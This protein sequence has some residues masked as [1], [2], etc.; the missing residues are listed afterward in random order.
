MWVQN[1][2]LSAINKTH[3]KCG[4]FCLWRK[5]W[6]VELDHQSRWLC[7]KVLNPSLAKLTSI[8]EKGLRIPL[9]CD[10]II[11]MFMVE[12]I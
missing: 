3:R 2:S 12:L 7:V 8:L 1:P 5:D 4:V 10:I 6:S 9:F 11:L